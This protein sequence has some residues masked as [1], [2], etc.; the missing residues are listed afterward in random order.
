M[1][2][3][4]SCGMAVHF[5]V[6]L[7]GLT[8]PHPGASWAMPW[9]EVKCSVCDASYLTRCAI[10]ARLNPCRVYNVWIVFGR[11]MEVAHWAADFGT[12]AIVRDG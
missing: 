1:H 2:P 7:A 11:D 12:A 3:P 6:H 10:C 4:S 5:A 9:Y 8:S